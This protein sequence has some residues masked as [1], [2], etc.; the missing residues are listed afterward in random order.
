MK[1]MKKNKTIDSILQITKN[2]VSKNNNYYDYIVN[3]S[4]SLYNKQ[5]PLLMK[6][7]RINSLVLLKP[8]LKEKDIVYQSTK[9]SSQKEERYSEINCES[10]QYISPLNNIRRLKARSPKLPPLSPIFNSK[11]ILL[12]SVV[13]SRRNFC[14]N[15][16]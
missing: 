9:N 6:N 11:G 2:V 10:E 5:L 8:K 16:L 15:I 13:N 4:N 3:E 7:N 14:R 1:I 12:P